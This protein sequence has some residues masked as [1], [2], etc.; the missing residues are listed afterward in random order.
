MTTPNPIAT[1]H[2]QNGAQITVELMPHLAPNTVRSFIHLASQRAFDNHPIARV[3]PDFVVDASTHAFHRAACRY[4]I[5]NEAAL[6]PESVR[7]LP[8]LGTMCMGGL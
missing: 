8:D 4:L 7:M 2:M 5:H 6:W 3:E 1:L